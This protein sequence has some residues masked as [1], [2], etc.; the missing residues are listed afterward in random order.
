MQ[1]W[2]LPVSP[3]C[4]RS[5]QFLRV[6]DVETPEAFP[7]S[8]SNMSRDRPPASARHHRRARAQR[9]RLWAMV[10]AHQVLTIRPMATATSMRLAPVHQ[11]LGGTAQE[12]PCWLNRWPDHTGVSVSR[13][14]NRRPWERRGWNPRCHAPIGSGNPPEAPSNS[15]P[16]WR[17]AGLSPTCS[18]ILPVISPV[19]STS[20]RWASCCTTQGHDTSCDGASW[21]PAHPRDG[22]SLTMSRSRE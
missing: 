5:P 11:Q 1:H 15:Q 6:Q 21:R 12:I 19:F 10:A 14:P 8:M 20:S 17:Q 16:P 22:Q 3:V 4:M 7:G 18:R 9:E 13:C 2:R